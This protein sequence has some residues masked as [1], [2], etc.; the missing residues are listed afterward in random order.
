[1]EVQC[2]EIGL[3]RRKTF[4]QSLL[5]QRLCGNVLIGCAPSS[6]RCPLLKKN[7]VVAF[8]LPY[9]LFSL[10]IVLIGCA[11][12]YWRWG[13]EIFFDYHPIILEV[14]AVFICFISFSLP[15]FPICRSLGSK[16]GTVLKLLYQVSCL[17]HH[18]WWWSRWRRWWWRRWG[19]SETMY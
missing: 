16:L 10:N 2:N 4:L 12:S 18:R 1:M 5:Q 13:S 14:S 9:F 8:Y 7:I 19:W 11:Q 6:W 15:I 3:N 17:H